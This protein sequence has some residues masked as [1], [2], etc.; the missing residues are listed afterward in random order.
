MTP[1]LRCLSTFYSETGSTLRSLHMRYQQHKLILDTFLRIRRLEICWNNS[2]MENGHEDF[3][4]H[5][6]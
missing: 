5:L 3:E 2:E 4:M 1:P 6:R